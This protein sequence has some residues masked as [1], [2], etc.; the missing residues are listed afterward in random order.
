MTTFERAKSCNASF[1]PHIFMH[2]RQMSDNN[3]VSLNTKSKSKCQKDR[4]QYD[5]KWRDLEW[6]DDIECLL[7]DADNQFFNK[8]EFMNSGRTGRRTVSKICDR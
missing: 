8:K 2:A 4:M 5:D 7:A 3:K 6:K 1:N